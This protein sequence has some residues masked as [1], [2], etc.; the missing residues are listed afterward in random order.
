MHKRVPQG[1]IAS[2]VTTRLDDVL[3]SVPAEFGSFTEE[4]MNWRPG[5]KRWSVAECLEH[6]IYTAKQYE[7]AIAKAT[8]GSVPTASDSN[9]VTSSLVGR[10]FLAMVEPEA[11]RKAIAPGAFNPLKDK[12]SRTSSVE[13]GAVDRFVETHQTLRDIVSSHQHIDWHRV[14]VVSPITSLVRF[15]LGD[16]FTLLATH[17]QR[18]VNQAR[19]VAATEGFPPG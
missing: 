1:E 7:P 13:A 19:R 18:H 10:F 3:A 6:L 14:R 4:Q 15:R 11:K 16:A 9:P 12:T 2:D 17:A 8:R 5:A